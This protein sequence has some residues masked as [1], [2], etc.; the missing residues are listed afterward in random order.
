ML[1][2][3]WCGLTIRDACCRRGSVRVLCMFAGIKMHLGQKGSEIYIL[4]LQEGGKFLEVSS[5]RCSDG[6]FLFCFQIEMDGTH[7]NA[8]E[9]SLDLPSLGYQS[10]SISDGY[11]C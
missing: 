6:I 11:T 8:V 3:L 9:C 7:W 5:S 1:R 2:E 10:E 4:V